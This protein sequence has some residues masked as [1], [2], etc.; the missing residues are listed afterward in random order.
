MATKRDIEGRGEAIADE[1]TRMLEG[2]S[3]EWPGYLPIRNIIPMLRRGDLLSPARVMKIERAKWD[4]T[5]GDTGGRWGKEYREIGDY[6]K[7]HVAV[8]NR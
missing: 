6:I 7:E 2:L 8:L 1:L 3:T 5:V 4:V